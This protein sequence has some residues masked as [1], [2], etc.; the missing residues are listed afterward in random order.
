MHDVSIV[1]QQFDYTAVQEYTYGEKMWEGQLVICMLINVKSVV[2]FLLS[3]SQNPF[4][5][6]VLVKSWFL[7]E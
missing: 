7:K 5:K 6:F 2:V 3:L 1:N 4:A